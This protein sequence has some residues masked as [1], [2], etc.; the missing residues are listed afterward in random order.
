MVQYSFDDF[1][2]QFPELS[3][4][5]LELVEAQRSLKGIDAKTRQLINI[6]IQT[7]NRNLRGVR[8]HAFMAKKAGATRDEV[9]GAVA[10][11]LHLRGVG[12]VL[13]TMPAAIAG[14]ESKKA[15]R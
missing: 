5:Y 12:V 15:D 13:D 11:N 10:L 4:R 2:K 9:L 6:G 14:F 8:Y 3:A 7:A 1:A